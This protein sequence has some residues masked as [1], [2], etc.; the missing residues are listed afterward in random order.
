MSKNV[1]SPNQYGS[2]MIWF[3]LFVYLVDYF[4]K[5]KNP[6]RNFYSGITQQFLFM[7]F[8]FNIIIIFW[9]ASSS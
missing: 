6:G 9:G 8:S 3:T 4:L 1:V 5:A 7:S 2:F